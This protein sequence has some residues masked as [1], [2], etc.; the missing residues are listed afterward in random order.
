[1][2]QPREASFTKFN[3]LL[4][5]SKQVERKLI[6]EALHRLADGGFR[7]SNY[8]YLGFG[9]IYYADFILFHKYLYIDDMICVE[10]EPIPKRMDFNKPFDFIRL[11]MK[12]VS[13]VL[14][15]LDRAKKYVVW[16]DY[17]YGL[18][19]DVLQDTAGFLHI[20][21]P[22]SILLVTVDAEPRLPEGEEYEQLSEDDRVKRSLE[23]LRSQFT[24]YY[25][26]EIKRN[27]LT[28][29]AFP[30]FLAEVLRAQ[31]FE[32]VSKRPG[33]KFFQ[34]FNFKY[35]DGAQ[36]LSLGGVIGDKVV[37]AQLRKSG[38]YNLDF[39]ERGS[40]PRVISV[41]PLTIREK[42]WLDRNLKVR[43]VAKVAFELESGMLDNFK[44]Y[45]RHY[46]TY[47]ETLI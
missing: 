17:D 16:L 2:S 41:P 42:Q 36:M 8:T 10:S 5:P 20:L 7:I 18:D 4:R 9:S 24:R 47:Y 35:A 25:K 19:E 46:P 11:E 44:K 21:S 31:F 27:L 3:Y 30:R 23:I 15:N 39:I 1:M 13:Y 37:E 45:Y 33:L 6:I 14:P 22:G 38:I 12:K 43:K 32:E 40:D 26:P 34:L 28:P 29:N